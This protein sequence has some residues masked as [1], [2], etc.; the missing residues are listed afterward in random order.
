M[1][2]APFGTPFK[3]NCSKVSECIP[4]EKHVRILCSVQR[5]IYV[6]LARSL[7]DKQHRSGDLPF[8]SYSDGLTST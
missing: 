6:L 7:R 3:T 2:H 4:N 5:G 8:V 1:A